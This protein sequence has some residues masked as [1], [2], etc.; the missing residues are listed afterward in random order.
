M[1]VLRTAPAGCQETSQ[2]I[3]YPPGT[4]TP[5]LFHWTAHSVPSVSPTR[6]AASGDSACE[7]C[8]VYGTVSEFN[9]HDRTHAPLSLLLVIQIATLGAPSVPLNG[10]PPGDRFAWSRT[11]AVLDTSLY[12]PAPEH[13]LPIWEADAANGERQDWQLY[14]GW[15]ET[16]YEGNLLTRGWNGKVRDLLGRIGPG[17]GTD[18]S[19][20]RLNILGR[21]IASEWAKNNRVRLLDTGDV[22][23]WGKLLDDNRDAAG[24]LAAIEVVSAEVARRLPTDHSVRSTSTGSTRVAPYAGIQQASRATIVNRRAPAR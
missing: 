6:R 15:V 19:L 23:R 10:G 22:R 24:L 11:L 21:V 1:F 12:Q 18:E 14:Y 9:L 5:F 16:F 13:F 8:N 4:R 3:R 17:P 7:G 20:R 2:C